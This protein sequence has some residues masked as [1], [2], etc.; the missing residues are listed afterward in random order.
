MLKTYT[1]Y[2]RDGREGTRFEPALC[3]DDVEALRRARELL[4]L[5]AECQAVE[6]FFGETRLFHVEREPKA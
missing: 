6:V 1:I 2:L 4:A 3:R 5:H